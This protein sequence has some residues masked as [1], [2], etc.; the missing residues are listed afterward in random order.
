MG[1]LA[2]EAP[3]PRR[4]AAGI[5]LDPGL[6]A[7]HGAGTDLAAGTDLTGGVSNRHEGGHV[8][9]EPEHRID[10]GV[11]RPQVDLC[12]DGDPAVHARL[13][14]AVVKA[15]QLSLAPLGVGERVRMRR[16]HATGV[17][18]SRGHEIDDAVVTT[19]TGTPR[20]RRLH[21]HRP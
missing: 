1:D 5:A 11:V 19:Q 13:G 2:L 20:R 21:G 6:G 16:K 15:H 3:G 9:N 12:I 7:S 18:R 4:R 10:P 8:V 14:R 17:Q